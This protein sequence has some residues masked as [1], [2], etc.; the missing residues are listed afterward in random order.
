MPMTNYKDRVEDTTTTAGSGNI[1]LAG[2]PPTGR[3]S[4]N[5]AFGSGTETTAVRFAYVIQSS[6]ESEWE[7]GIGYLSASTT[8]IRET[9]MQSSNSNNAVTFSAGT[10][11]VFGSLIGYQAQR[12]FGAGRSILMSQRNFLP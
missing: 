10:K 6:D 12:F 1:T 7:T 3:I 11:K 4:F 9:V 8:L 2:A 5:T